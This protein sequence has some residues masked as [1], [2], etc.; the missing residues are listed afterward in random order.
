MHSVSS[1]TIND[2]RGNTRRIIFLACYKQ[3]F[4]HFLA[5]SL[6]H[7]QHSYTSKIELQKDFQ[8]STSLKVSLNKIVNTSLSSAIVQIEGKC[9]SS[10]KL[11]RQQ[12]KKRNAELLDE[13]WKK[14]KKKWQWNLHI[15]LRLTEG[16]VSV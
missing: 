14:S 1:L 15:P 8:K 4:S 7:N 6:S 13:L 3:L 2:K 11:A 10:L 9:V 5:P 16:F 12:F